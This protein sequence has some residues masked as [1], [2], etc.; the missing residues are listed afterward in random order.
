M[1]D[2]PILLITFNR[3]NHTRKVLESIR[4][5]KPSRL[6]VFQDG[7][8]DDVESDIEKCQSVRDV[9]NELVDWQCELKMFYSDVNLGF[10][11]GPVAALTWFFAYI[12]C[13]LI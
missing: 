6:F 13:S 10:G 8:R 11:P 9:I 7:V 2:T 3:P 12:E 5:Q 1:F 4:K